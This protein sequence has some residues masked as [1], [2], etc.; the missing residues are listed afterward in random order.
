MVQLV[1]QNLIT[2]LFLHYK[3]PSPNFTPDLLEGGGMMINLPD[4]MAR[5]P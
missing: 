4:T 5:S 3:D 1:E 2:G